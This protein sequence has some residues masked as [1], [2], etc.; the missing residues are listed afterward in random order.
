MKASTAP[1]AALED[2]RSQLADAQEQ[3][4]EAEHMAAEAMGMLEGAQNESKAL[5]VSEATR[6]RSS[7]RAPHM[8]ITTEGPPCPWESFRLFEGATAA[9]G[10]LVAA[11]VRSFV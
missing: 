7:C 5:A 11:E 8:H 3:M 9:C 6:P 10:R 1:V 4:A 2:L